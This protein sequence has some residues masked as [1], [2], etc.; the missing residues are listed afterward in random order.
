MN[1][2]SYLIVTL[3]I[4]CG[5]CLTGCKMLDNATF[6]KKETPVYNTDGTPALSADGRPIFEQS[7][8]PSSM[9]KG[10]VAVAQNLP[11]PFN[12]IGTALGAALA[13]VCEWRRRRYVKNADG[14][15]TELEEAND[16]LAKSL[17]ALAVA[18][19]QLWDALDNVEGGDKVIAW[20]D[21]FA[22]TNAVASSQKVLEFISE[23]LAKTTTPDKNLTGLLT[24]LQSISAN[25][26]AATTTA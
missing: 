20:Y 13:G 1:K 23:T 4:L 25:G 3:L 2:I 22:K 18:R 9:A 8:E 15:I 10:A 24:T 7:V 26:T 14:T 17:N 16:T 5:V 11:S 6:T 12:W 19:D 21:N